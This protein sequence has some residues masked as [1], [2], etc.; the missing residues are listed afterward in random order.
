MRLF[1]N[2]SMAAHTSFKIG[3]PAEIFAQAESRE[4]LLEIAA[5]CR[6]RGVRLSL[7]G[8]GT[9]VLINDGGL[10]GVTVQLYPHFCKHIVKGS[11]VTAEAGLTL[12]KLAETAR[13][14]GLA[15]M[16]FASGIPGSVGGA[17]YM[18]AGAYGGEM[19]QIFVSAEVLTPDGNVRTFY[20]NEMGF[21]YR[22]SI[23]QD[24]G[25]IVLSAT[26][27]LTP[28]DPVEIQKK[29]VELNARR[30]EKQPLDFPSAGSTFKR[31]EGY[32]AGELIAKSGLQGFAIGGA[33]V[34]EKHAGFIVNAG[35]ATADDVLKL[36]E[37][38]KQTVYAQFGVALE[39]EVKVL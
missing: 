15:G 17:A 5:L 13:E 7:L 29:T 4:E 19:A 32:Y 37:H 3:G 39:P 10:S 16:E 31:P 30:R 18:N 26:L 2:E 11:T 9:N 36:I 8:C 22:R 28:G 34:S 33:R 35:G 38:V 25:G 12:H 21:A 24:N 6:K 14:Y 23:L 20:K 1:T 27:A